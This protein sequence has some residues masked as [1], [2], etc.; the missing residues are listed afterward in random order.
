VTDT[1]IFLDG[2]IDVPPDRL[3]AVTAALPAHI[4]LTRAE[5]GC[6]SFSVEPDAD[7]AGRFT[8]SEVFIDQAAF[9]AH[10]DRM[11][12]SEWFAVT[13]GIPRDYVIRKASED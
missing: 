7:I 4:A 3:D 8:V 9:D 11:R 6:L 2:Y 12:S 10:Q 1:R 5:P 13:K